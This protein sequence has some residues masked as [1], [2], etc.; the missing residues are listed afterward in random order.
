MQKLLEERGSW[1]DNRTVISLGSLIFFLNIFGWKARGRSLFISLCLLSS[2]NW[3]IFEKY[4]TKFFTCISHAPV[5]ILRKGSDFH[6]SEEEPAQRPVNLPEESRPVPVPLPLQSDEPKIPVE[7]A[8]V[9]PCVSDMAL[10]WMT[11]I[12]FP[13]TQ[14]VQSVT[15]VFADSFH[16]HSSNS[17]PLNLKK[18]PTGKQQKAL[19]SATCSGS[20]WKERRKRE[21]QIRHKQGK[22]GGR[23]TRIIIPEYKLLWSQEQSNVR[24]L[25]TQ[26]W[27]WD[28]RDGITSLRSFGRNQME[29]RWRGLTPFDPSQ[30]SRV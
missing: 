29:A 21:W 1:P 15:C 8:R 19:H 23:E 5:G 18:Q 20:R 9:W 4:F 17:K 6:W 22:Q 14:R 26:N 3:I 25:S 12:H 16:F 2:I 7:S 30:Q 11:N 27:L 28:D 13:L 24:H 10:R